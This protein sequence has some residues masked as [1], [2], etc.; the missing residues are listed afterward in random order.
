VNALFE[1]T[2]AESRIALLLCDD[3]APPEIA[4]LMREY[5]HLKTN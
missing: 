1:L 2:P 5:E 3:H 4:E